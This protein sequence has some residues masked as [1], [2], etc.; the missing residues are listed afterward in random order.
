MRWW[1]R[2]LDRWGWSPPE[3]EVQAKESRA[4]ALQQAA[5]DARQEFEDSTSRTRPLIERVE[6]MAKAY[7]REE[8]LLAA[9]RRKP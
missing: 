7:A 3:H 4:E 8:A 5:A 6:R 2:M 1:R 9:R